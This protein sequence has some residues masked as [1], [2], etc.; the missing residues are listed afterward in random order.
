MEA[1][2]SRSALADDYRS[3]MRRLAATVCILTAGAGADRRGMTATAVMS[4]SADPPLIAAAVNRSSSIRERLAEGAEF[5]VNLLAEGQD[6]LARDFAGGLPP[7]RRFERGD[8]MG[9]EDEPPL[10]AD[11]VAAII[12]TVERQIEHAS[13]CLIIGRVIRVRLTEDHRPLVYAH[14]A[15]TALHPQCR[16][17]A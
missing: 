17:P 11:A 1:A 14:G 12:C 5:T 15:F 7:D 8:W 2:G 4:F 9:G 10:L 6:A 3:A 16:A 13:H